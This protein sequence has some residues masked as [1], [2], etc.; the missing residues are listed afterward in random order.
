MATNS[1]FSMFRLVIGAAFPLGGATLLA[2]LVLD[3]LIIRRVP[4][5]KH[6][7]S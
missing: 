7:L 1:P 4:S 6:A 3:W 2:V 5:L